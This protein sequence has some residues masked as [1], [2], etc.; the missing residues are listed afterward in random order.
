M[1]SNAKMDLKRLIIF[2]LLVFALACSCADANLMLTRRGARGQRYWFKDGDL[3]EYDTNDLTANIPPY[4]NEIHFLRNE[5]VNAFDV[6][7]NGHIVFSAKRCARIGELIG[8]D[9]IYNGDLVEYDPVS[10]KAS[11]FFDEQL[12]SRNE[13]IDAVDI[14]P[15]GH[16]I[17]STA[18]SATLGG[19]S[20]LDGDLIEYDP[21]ADVA[22]LFFSEK[23]FF[24][25]EDIDAVD[26]MPDGSILFSTQ[27][28]GQLRGLWFTRK[29]IV[30]FYP[31]DYTGDSSLAGTAVLYFDAGS[32]KSKKPDFDCIA[33]APVPEPATILLL[34]LGSL[35]L[36]RRR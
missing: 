2:G 5:K 19:L 28:N 31:D 11:L 27:N 14:L 33:L 9:Y 7:P 26:V 15:N 29:D 4:F 18:G 30:R 20:F 3:I 8:F 1:D 35:A 12:F 6:L 22:T 16:I 17:L 23:M 13:D 36:R 21:I 10:G 24:K 32:F 25:N 34:A